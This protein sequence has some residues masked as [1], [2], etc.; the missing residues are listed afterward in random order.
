MGFH[1]CKTTT[2]LSVLKSPLAADLNGIPDETQKG[3]AVELTS[4][5]RLCYAF[6][7]ITF[8]FN[9]INSSS[10]NASTCICW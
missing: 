5:S 9:F 2:E 6:K 8:G 10:S 3:F 1:V 4:N 7:F